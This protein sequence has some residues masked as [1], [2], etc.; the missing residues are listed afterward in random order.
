MNATTLCWWKGER[1]TLSLGGGGGG[2]SRARGVG[3]MNATSF[4]E[5]T[6]GAADVQSSSCS[7]RKSG[8]W[9]C[10]LFDYNFPLSLSTKDR[11]WHRF[12]DNGLLPLLPMLLSLHHLQRNGG[13][14]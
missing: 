12:E 10:S 13:G 4:G 6:I 2:G 14:V 3:W 1:E 7:K 11:Y 9:R 5:G 8:R